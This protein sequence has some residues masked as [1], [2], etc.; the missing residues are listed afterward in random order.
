MCDTCDNR[1]FDNITRNAHHNILHQLLPSVSAAAAEN[2]SYYLVCFTVGFYLLLLYFL[3]H[4][5][6]VLYIAVE[7]VRYN[8]LIG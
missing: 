4:W 2:Y 8:L 7:F 5:Y 6:P 3:V 1:L